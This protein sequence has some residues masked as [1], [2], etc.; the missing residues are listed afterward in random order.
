MSV[1]RQIRF[2]HLF[3]DSQQLVTI[4]SFTVLVSSPSK[5]VVN[6]VSYYIHEIHSPLRLMLTLS[7]QILGSG[8]RSF[9]DHSKLSAQ[10]KLSLKDFP[11]AW[12]EEGITAT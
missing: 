3:F 5:W 10:R 1:S 9:V 4:L 6:S 7:Y 12:R 2:L 8:M 11:S